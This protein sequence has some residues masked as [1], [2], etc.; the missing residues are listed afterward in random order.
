MN[1]QVNQ[2]LCIGCGLCSDV[3]PA[4]FEVGDDGLSHVIGAPSPGNADA[5]RDAAES[6]PTSAISL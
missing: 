2:E 5:V 1:L 3:A 6:C 4:V